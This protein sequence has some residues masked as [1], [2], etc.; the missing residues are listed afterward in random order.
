MP[1]T[2]GE[3]SEELQIA[4]RQVVANLVLSAP[5]GDHP[6]SI[7]VTS[8]QPGEGKTALAHGFAIALAQT[9]Q[10][11]LLLDANLG[12]PR[13]HTLFDAPNISGFSSLLENI[14]A[15]RIPDLSDATKVPGL[16]LLPAGQGGPAIA[17]RLF[18]PKLPTLFAALSHQFDVIVIDAPAVSELSSRPLIRAAE[19][20]IVVL[21]KRRD[22]FD[23]AVEAIQS[24][25]GDGAYVLGTVMNCR[26]PDKLAEKRD[27]LRFPV[28]R[29][30]G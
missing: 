16:F 25:A 6:R 7:A 20:V 10:R 8:A 14:G 5:A 15:R 4:V 28:P 24:L 23:K 12:R 17:Q 27:T 21:D 22:S 13:Q 3:K 1:D 19:G 11:V 26:V 29:N 18:S 9:N 2:T 30:A